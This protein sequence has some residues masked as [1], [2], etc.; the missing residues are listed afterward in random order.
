LFCLASDDA[1]LAGAKL[2]GMGLPFQASQFSTFR[3]GIRLNSLVLAVTTVVPGVGSDQQ[4]VAADWLARCFQLRSDAAIFG[5]GRRVERQ[6][7][8]L[9]KEV[10]DGFEYSLRAALGASVAQLGGHDDAGADVVSPALP[11]RFAAFPCGF[12]IRSE[13]MFVSSM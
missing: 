13:M 6:H 4:V 10:F 12:L 3:P 9:A 8:D 11:I 1:A 5:V 2:A 7:V